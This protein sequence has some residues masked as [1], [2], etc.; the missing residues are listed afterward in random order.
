MDGGVFGRRTLDGCT[1]YRQEADSDGIPGLGV[2]VF[3]LLLWISV[4]RL[5]PTS[6]HVARAPAQ[7]SQPRVGAVG[8]RQRMRQ[9]REEVLIEA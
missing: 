2:M 5:T 1:T 7:A 9:R 3:L 4:L 8:G 6:G